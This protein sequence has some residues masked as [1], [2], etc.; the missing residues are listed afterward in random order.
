MCT[1]SFCSHPA[2]VTGSL[3]LR[4][5]ALSCGGCG[6]GWIGSWQKMFVVADSGT[7]AEIADSGRTYCHTVLSYKDTINTSLYIDK[8]FIALCRHPT[9]SPKTKPTNTSQ[10]HRSQCN[11]RSFHR[12]SPLVWHLPPPFP[13]PALLLAPHCTH[14][15][16][17]C[18]RVVSHLA[19]EIAHT[20]NAT[21]PL[22]NR[23]ELLNRAPP[24]PTP[25]K[26]PF[27]YT[28]SLSAYIRP[29]IR[30]QR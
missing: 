21:S 26:P 23:T 28:A 12:V 25:A 30:K 17:R 6:G 15:H 16:P 27:T 10:R 8:R 20:S 13:R 19:T 4:R 3:L 24:S 22:L 1:R 7:S 29:T 11:I 5:V 18:Q 14:Q 2:S 9:C